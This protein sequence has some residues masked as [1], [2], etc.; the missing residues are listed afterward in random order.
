MNHDNKR[1]KMKSPINEACSNNV[2]NVFSHPSKRDT[3]DKGK[4]MDW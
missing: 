2:W 1:L 3:Q 4:Q